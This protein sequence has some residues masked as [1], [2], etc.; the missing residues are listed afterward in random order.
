MPVQVKEL[1]F[2]EHVDAG[3]VVKE[4]AKRV[5]FGV[6]GR[7]SAQTSWVEEG[8]GLQRLDRGLALGHRHSRAC[9]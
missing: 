7:L 4:V 6:H 5:A 8:E 1:T 9:H 2:L 3:M